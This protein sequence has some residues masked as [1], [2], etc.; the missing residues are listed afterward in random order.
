[1]LITGNGGGGNTGGLA[2]PKV[3][4]NIIRIE[5]SPAAIIS[6][7]IFF[8]VVI[9]SMLLL[10]PP[11]YMFMEMMLHIKTH[12]RHSP[13]LEQDTAYIKH[14]FLDKELIYYHSRAL[15]LFSPS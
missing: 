10:I 2:I 14:H 6:I 9:M 15:F 5:N 11:E 13:E 4:R 8:I 1:M 12:Y 7:F 3:G